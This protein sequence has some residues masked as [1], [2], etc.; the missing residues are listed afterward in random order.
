MRALL[1]V[2]VLIAVHDPDHLHHARALDWLAAE[3]Q[4]GWASCP[5]TQNGC[6]RILSQPGYVNP[7][8]LAQVVATLQQSTATAHHR[9]WPDDLS[10]LEAAAF[11]LSKVHGHRQ[12][13]DLYLLGLAV[14]H[15]G[16][17][18]TFDQ[19]IPLGAVRGAAPGHL[20]VL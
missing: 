15:G 20:V 7:L 10:V 3:I 2:N 18:V 8:P 6:L 19:R 4:H 14:R 13:T 9:F 16:R 5:L 11:D 12:L 17:L 1:D